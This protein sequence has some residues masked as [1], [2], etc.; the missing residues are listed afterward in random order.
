VSKEHWAV[1]GHAADA[2]APA[3][4]NL[5][6]G[7]FIGSSFYGQGIRQTTSS[8]QNKLFAIFMALVLSTSLA[9]Q[10]QPI[11]MSFRNLYEARE[12]PSKL[13]AWPVAIVAAILVEIPWNFVGTT[14]FFIP[15]YF[16][17]FHDGL[18]ALRGFYMWLALMFFAVYWHTFATAC[19]GIAPNPQLASVLFSVFFS[20]VIVFCGV[21]QP[22]PLMPKFWSSWMFPLSP[23]TY[24]LEGL[25]GN[26]LGGE[27]IVCAANELNTLNPPA[28]QSCE[29]F[30]GAYF[31]SGAPG[32]FVQ[33]ADGSCGTCAYAQAETFLSSLSTSSL[34]LSSS[35]KW[36]NLGIIAAYIAF[37]FFL[38]LGLFW[39]FRIHQWKGKK[40][41][42]AKTHASDPAAAAPDASAP[43]TAAAALDP[44]NEKPTAPAK[45]AAVQEQGESALPTAAASPARGASPVQEQRT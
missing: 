41:A 27:A 15:W 1:R 44:H 21:V 37:N 8:L 28:G 20:F 35:H 2:C 31:A 19:A 3:S 4:L 10:A 9:Q 36:R 23:F 7:L 25:L 11:F 13:Y 33:N 45:M 12:R 40:N 43:Q 6:A 39:A 42:P 32:Y 26:V 14:T 22:P 17:I 29:Q 18:G 38:C 5:F 34:T 30:L 24:L 16:F